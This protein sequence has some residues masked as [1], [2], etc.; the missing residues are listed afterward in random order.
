MQ[1]KIST[2]YSSIDFEFILKSVPGYVYWKDLNGVYLGCNQNVAT[3]LGLDDPDEIIG[4]TEF[5]L[6]W[7]DLPEI[8]NKGY[9]DDSYVIKTGKPF[10]TEERLGIT[11][12]QGL[13]IILRT[14][15]T[16]LIDQDRNVIGILG[17]GVDITDLKFQE[18]QKIE[19]AV[20]KEKIASETILKEQKNIYSS[21]ESA[22]SELTGQK[23]SNKVSAQ[24]YI[25]EM[26]HF[27][28]NV[29]LKMPGY[30]FL[31]DK[32]F[33]YLFCNEMVNNDFLEFS[34]PSDIV[35]KTDYDFG[36]NKS[37]VDEYRKI[38]EEIIKTGQ[39][40]LGIE[41]IVFTANGK[42]LCLIVNKM[43][44]F[45]ERG[46]VVG[47]I[48]VN[49]DITSQK[50]AERWRLGF[51]LNKR[52]LEDQQ[53]FKVIVDQ[54]AHDI[55]SPLASLMMIMKTCQ[56]IP[57]K[58]R[59]ALRGAATTITDIANNLLSY[60]NI[61]STG[62]NSETE[63]RQPILASS[64]L[65]QI[66]TEKKYQ[67]ENLP[68]EFDHV[69]SPSG[70]FSLIQVD[71]TAFKRTISNLINNAVDAFEKKSGKVTLHLDANEDQVT[72]IIQDDGKGMSPEL[73]DKIMNNIAVTEGKQDG[74]G[75]GLT[76]VRETLRDNKGVLK[77]ESEL[78]RGT[79][80]IL[81]FPRMQSDSIYTDHIPLNSNDTVII[82][83]DESSI[84]TAWDLR[85]QSLETD[86]PNIIIKH[87][88]VGQEVVDYINGLNSNQKQKIFLLTDYELLSQKI[89]GLDVIEFAKMNRAVLVTSHDANKLV[90]ER[91]EKL[92]VQILSKQL[93]ADVPFIVKDFVANT[94][95]ALADENVHKDV[96]FIFVDDDKTLLSTLEMVYGGKKIA[97]YNNPQNFFNE[98]SQY[99]PHT[100]IFID[101]NFDNYDR[102][103]IEIIRQLGESGFTNLYLL[104]GD[105]FS[106]SDMPPYL[107]VILKTDIDMIDRVINYHCP[108]LE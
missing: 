93:A 95:D 5:D 91:A 92:G 69:F 45:N 57:E 34:S 36:W 23:F 98:I 10:V 101:N 26:R 76:Q 78:G 79:K 60:Y 48:G 29:I 16:P 25:N 59:V 15:K 9:S 56:S 35:G 37:I 24:Y 3:L 44:L 89:T 87:F 54:V 105:N 40:K 50:E 46:E 49:V 100:C 84:H 67:Y 85:F 83:D 11:N 106:S 94:D 52:A 4:K 75:I 39:P 65:L 80:I 1:A 73:I 55:R 8:I 96:E 7:K 71:P 90:M 20:A 18:K 82:L 74:H 2:E 43:P 28:Q 53:K 51:E 27:L 33:K 97:T 32:D 61:E 42:P 70:N 63:D 66:Q 72:V 38:D 88:S 14:E 21:L 104:S 108:V 17:I 102:S 22:V 99:H 47:I 30:V 12:N 13:E 81:T 68:I 77:I 19:H 103:G 64:V 86:Y 62:E 107:K 58:E 41:E 31:K 6:P